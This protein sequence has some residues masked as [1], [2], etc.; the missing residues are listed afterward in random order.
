[1]PTARQIFESRVAS[2]T[3]SQVEHSIKPLTLSEIRNAVQRVF[4]G[5]GMREVRKGL[6]QA[7][8]QRQI[9]GEKVGTKTYYKMNPNYVPPEPTQL[10]SIRR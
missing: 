2:E 4:R 5:A 7:E 9:L 6:K 1:M 10:E 8:R 3:V